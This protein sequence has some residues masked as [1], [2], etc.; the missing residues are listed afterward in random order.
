MT[1]R[2]YRRKHR[3][4]K[5]SSR[6]ICHPDSAGIDIS[7]YCMY[8][9]VPPDRSPEPVRRFSAFTT[10]LRAIVDWLRACGITTVAMES[11]GVYWIPLY[12]MLS[13]AGLEVYLVNARHVKNV[14]GRK[15]DVTDAEWL[16]YLHSVGLLRA[17]FRPPQVICA[18]RSLSRHRESLLKQAGQQVQYM[19][20][21]LDEMNLHLHH[22]I[23]DLTGKTGLAIVQAMLD[24]QRDPKQLAQLRDYRIKAQPETIVKAL[25]GDYREEHLFVLRQALQTWRHLQTQLSECD[26]EMERLTNRLEAKVDDSAYP[27]STKRGVSKNQPEGDW[28]RILYHSFGADL[29]TVPGIQVSTGHTLLVEIGTDWSAFPTA[30]HFAS[31]LTLC[32]DNDTS[33]EKVLRRRTRRAQQR[34]K[35]ILRMAARSLHKS[36]TALGAKYRRLRTRLGAPKAITAMAHQLARILWHL[37]THQVSYDE[38]V[39]ADIELK[40][41]QR[42]RKRLLAEARALGLQFVET[43]SVSA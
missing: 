11:T 8:V 20:K 38:S 27:K 37:V 3:Q 29:T 21:A 22:V 13:D 1:Q 39:F 42:R 19:Q 7:P 9:A 5:M 6:P 28:H 30:G 25:E 18:I 43:Q 14:P 33:G 40:H 24:G 16:Q 31:W 23:D 17:S 15:S 10:D 36:Q 41:Q 4:S 26:R 34:V 2:Q 12:Q 32:P 35:L